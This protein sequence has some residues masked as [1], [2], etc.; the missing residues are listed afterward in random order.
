[1]LSVDLF[2][3]T[4]HAPVQVSGNERAVSVSL[5]YVSY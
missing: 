5:E 4:P 3:T 2:P 1:M